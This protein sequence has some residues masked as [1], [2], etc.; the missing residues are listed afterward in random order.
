MELGPKFSLQKKKK[1]IEQAEIRVAY[2]KADKTVDIGTTD[3]F[4]TV[5]ILLPPDASQDTSGIENRAKEVVDFAKGY[6]SGHPQEL[7]KL[8]YQLTVAI[9]N[10]TGTAVAFNIA[11]VAKG[12]GSIQNP[13]INI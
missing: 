1:E 10:S 5:Q 3:N 8:G 9:V 12:T 6:F 4:Y 7:H 13:I 11:Y 2:N